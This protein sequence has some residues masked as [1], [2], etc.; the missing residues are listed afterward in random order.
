[1]VSA[2]QAKV[3]KPCPDQASASALTLLEWVRNPFSSTNASITADPWREYYRYNFIISF[4]A[5]MQG[6]MLMSPLIF[7]VNRSLFVSYS[8]L[9]LWS[10]FWETKW[11]EA[12][13]NISFVAWLDAWLIALL[14]HLRPRYI[15]TVSNCRHSIW[16]ILKLDKNNRFLHCSYR[17]LYMYVIILEITCMNHKIWTRM[18][19]WYY[20]EQ[21][22]HSEYM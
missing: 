9:L 4:Q 19:Q 8:I 6:F 18:H 20:V 7:G 5:L 3:L 17:S 15:H 1:M 14:F 11:R 22:V 2:C 16:L 13:I 21:L 10:V 12:V